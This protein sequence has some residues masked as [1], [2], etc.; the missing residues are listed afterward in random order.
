MMS[1]LYPDD[2][3]EGVTTWADGFGIW[4]ATANSEQEALFAIAKAL[5]DRGEP[6]DGLA[7]EHVLG[8]HWKET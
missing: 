5:W 6:T 3:A 1:G 7:V 8:R 4:H 2:Q